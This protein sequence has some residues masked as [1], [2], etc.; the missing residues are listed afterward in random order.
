MSIYDPISGVPA[1]P[2]VAVVNTEERTPCAILVDC[3]A[4]MNGLP[5]EQVNEG[6][7]L[8][9]REIK[10]DPMTAAKVVVSV[11]GF[12]TQHGVEILTDWVE[13]ENFSAP[14]VTA[15]GTT[16]MGEAVD[17]ALTRIQQLKSFLKSS[18]ITYRRPWLFVLT[19]GAPT[20]KWEQPAARCTAAVENR[21]VIAWAITTEP[22]SLHILQKF[23]GNAKGGRVV[24]IAGIDL[25]SMFVWLSNSM[26]TVSSAN[27]GSSV[28]V[29][30]PPG[31]IIDL[32]ID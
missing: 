12:G 21:Q 28:Q 29:P 22:R 10:R 30:A 9:E 16:P 13:G 4:S 26:A 8:F 6:L 23:V 5:I 7:Q 27:A 2:N 25:R 18:G 20:D 19:D 24:D 11:I 3:S 14:T 17:L 15:Y 31:R 32:D 1:V